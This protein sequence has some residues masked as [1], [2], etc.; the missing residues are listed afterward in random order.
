MRTLSPSV[1]HLNDAQREY[2]I[3]ECYRSLI[4]APDAAAKNAKWRQL[5]RLN[6]SRSADAIA[7]LEQERGQVARK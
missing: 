7:R 5:A 2:A 6:K 1:R 4:V 3:H